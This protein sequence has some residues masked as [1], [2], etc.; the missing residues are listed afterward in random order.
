MLRPIRSSHSL[1]VA[2]ALVAAGCG[3]SDE[4]PP[5]AGPD[6]SPPLEG[7]PAGRLLAS[8]AVTPAPRTEALVDR[9][10]KRAVLL[11]RERVLEVYDAATG[12]RLGR[13]PAGAGPT[14]VLAA[15]GGLAYVIDTAGD[16]LLVFETRGRLRIRRRYPLPGAPYGAA[17]DLDNG[18]LWV[19]LTA[20]NQLVELATSARPH[21]L[22]VYPTVRQPDAVAVEPGTGR[23]FV[24]GADG[25]VQLLDP[26]RSR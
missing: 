11:P 21:R 14:H 5:A 6:R 25:A 23:V 7:P 22:N 8:A 13:A 20:R 16:G 17:S 10:R 19:A 1:L 26:R 12:Q 15:E 2:L 4:L 18:R 3:S 9:K 24:R